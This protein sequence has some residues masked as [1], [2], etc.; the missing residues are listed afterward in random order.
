MFPISFKPVV[1]WKRAFVPRPSYVTDIPE[2]RT[3]GKFLVRRDAMLYHPWHCRFARFNHRFYPYLRLI[4]STALYIGWLSRRVRLFILWSIFMWQ[5]N[6]FWLSEVLLMA[7]INFR[8]CK[9]CDIH[10]IYILCQRYEHS[11]E[12]NSLHEYFIKQIL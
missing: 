9:R 11:M 5:T 2:S 3:F 8:I 1:K 6:C 12:N 4:K 10:E 7:W